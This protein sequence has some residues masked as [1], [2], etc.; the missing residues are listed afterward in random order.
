MYKII[1]YCLQFNFGLMYFKIDN[2]WWT[3]IFHNY[4]KKS[5]K[6]YMYTYIAIHVCVI[7][8][9]FRKDI[10]AG[11]IFIIAIYSKGNLFVLLLIIIIL[12]FFTNCSMFYSISL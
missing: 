1:Q 7:I 9:I 4:K 11:Q 5:L 2:I 8:F 6:I 12:H 3:K 10:D